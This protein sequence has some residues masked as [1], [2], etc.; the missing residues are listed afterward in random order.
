MSIRTLVI[1]A[2]EQTP[3][4]S[5]YP[6]HGNFSIVGKSLPESG[7]SFYQPV[8]EWLDKG[9]EKSANIL[10]FEFSLEQLN[11]SSSKMLLFILYKLKEQKEAGKQVS[12]WWYHG[13][14]NSD[15]LEVGE[16]YEFMVDIPFRF[17]TGYLN[18]S[19]RE[20]FVA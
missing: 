6:E 10:N 18:L 16:D 13:D 7:E 8:L 2:T 1:E 15:I 9:L 5:F 14:E 12:V 19:H 3:K 11:L 20:L 17:K 4:V